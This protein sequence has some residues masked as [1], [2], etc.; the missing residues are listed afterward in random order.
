MPDAT[1]VIR[2]LHDTN[3]KE[4]KAEWITIDLPVDFRFRGVGAA[5][6]EQT[7]PGTGELNMTT[8]T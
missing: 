7:K 3:E 4:Y 8:R 6:P 2:D 5:S 1:Q